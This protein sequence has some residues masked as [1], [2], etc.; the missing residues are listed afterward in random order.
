MA[1]WDEIRE[2]DEL[3]GVGTIARRYFVMNAFDGVVTI[4]GVIAGSYAAG[5]EDPRVVVTTGVS[6]SVAMGISGLWGAYLTE[7]AERER[8][9]GELQ[10]QMLTDLSQTKIGRAS[11]T[12]ILVV[13][14]VDGFSPFLAAIVA[15]LPFFFAGAF[16]QMRWVY[17]SGLGL[18]VLTLVAIGVFLGRVSR[19]N[20]VGYALRT[21]LAGM[22]ALVVGLL[23]GA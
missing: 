3:T 8:D 23:L 7:S 19:R 20:V 1:L 14:V 21:V 13:T 16:A 15:L 6:T 11:R 10:E 17:A 12:A 9:L 18:A 22:M 5:V 4:I 2:A